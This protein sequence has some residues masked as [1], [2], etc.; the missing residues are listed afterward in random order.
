MKLDNRPKKLLIKSVSDGHVQAVRD[1]YEVCLDSLML[2]GLFL[3]R[4]FLG[5]R[6]NRISGDNG[7]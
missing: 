5:D 3:T 7:W 1:W 2:E 6:A 4:L